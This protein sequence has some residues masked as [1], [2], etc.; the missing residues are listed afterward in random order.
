MVL[1]LVASPT[2]AYVWEIADTADGTFEA[3]ADAT[4][5]TYT[6]VVDDAGK[7]I[8]C[9]VTASVLGIGTITTA[10]KVVAAA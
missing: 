4:T 10:P 9:K 2:Y 3:I 7:F 6:P 5:A 1:L 8:R